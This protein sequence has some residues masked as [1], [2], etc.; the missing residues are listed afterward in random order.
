MLLH[1]CVSMRSN[2]SNS[3]FLRGLLTIHVQENTVIGIYCAYT[4]SFVSQLCYLEITVY[5]KKNKKTHCNALNDSR[6]VGLQG[7][8]L[9][10]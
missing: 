10:L 3:I 8:T 6:L 9:T 2:Y 4:L 5:H 1:V 7:L